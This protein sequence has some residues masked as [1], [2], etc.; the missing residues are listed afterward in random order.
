MI[1]FLLFIP[2]GGLAY[3]VRGGLW[4]DPIKSAAA[5]WGSTT[6]RISLSVLTSAF[7]VLLTFDAALFALAPALYAGMVLGWF[8]CGD[9]GRDGDRSRLVEGL[10]MTGRGLIMTAPVGAVLWGFGYGPWFGLAGLALGGLY[11]LGHRT[12]TLGAGFETGMPIA[13]V[14]TGIW[15]WAALAAAVTFA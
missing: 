12:P 5:W 15:I 3:R 11:E 8:G 10:I 13:E 7:A 14:Y 2:L 1:A 9:M 6:S 4:G